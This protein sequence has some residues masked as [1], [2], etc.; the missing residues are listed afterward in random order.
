MYARVTLLEID[1]VRVN[2]DEALATFEREVV[3]RLHDQPGFRG[4]LVFTNP[5]G[6]GLI[7]SFWDSPEAADSADS[8]FYG[9]TLAQYATLFRSA[10]A[11]SITRS[12]SRISRA[13]SDGH[14]LRNPDGRAGHRRGHLAGRCARRGDDARGAQPS[15][16]PPGPPVRGAP[17]VSHGADRPRVD[18]G[19]HHHHL[20]PG[21]QGHDEHDH[22]LVGDPVTRRGRQTWPSKAPTPK[23]SRP[24]WSSVAP[25]TSSTSTSP[26]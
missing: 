15:V 16:R 11:E 24:W 4:V 13:A 17:A 26:R 1:L 20:G 23:G 21:H 8:G 18:A 9:E 7:T 6:K 2:I 12:A 5:E 25:P 10:P 19:H 3:P 22:A 14:P